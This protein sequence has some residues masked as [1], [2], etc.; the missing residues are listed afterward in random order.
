MSLVESDTFTTTSRPART[1]ALPSGAYV[2]SLASLPSLYA[3]SSSTPTNAIHLFDKANLR[4]VATLPG[5]EKAVTCIRVVSN[6]SGSSRET[7]I[8]SGEDAL[9]KVWDERT[10]SPVLQSELHLPLF[11]SMVH[12]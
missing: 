5:H 4:A 10:T 1:A 11:S 8:S 2:L 6:I 12:S 7:L 3:A 9:I